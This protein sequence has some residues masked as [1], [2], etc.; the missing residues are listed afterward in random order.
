MLKILS[1][2]CVLIQS[3]C[4]LYLISSQIIGAVGLLWF[5]LWAYFVSNSPSF[6]KRISEDEKT[7]IMASLKNEV[8]NVTVIIIQCLSLSWYIFLLKPDNVWLV[9]C[10]FVLKCAIS[11]CSC[12][13]PQITS[14]GHRSL[15]L[16]HYGP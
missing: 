15:S 2:A 4:T 12:P 3:K 1:Q 6:H 13:Q 14:H 10:L 11:C 8:G 7:Y 9:N 16:C 5:V